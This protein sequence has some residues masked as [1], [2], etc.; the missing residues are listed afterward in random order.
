M[1]LR[2]L[3]RARLALDDPT[4]LS[5]RHVDHVGQTLYSLSLSI[6]PAP[7]RS[8]GTSWASGCSAY[9]RSLPIGTRP[10]H[11][12]CPGA[13]PQKALMDLEPTDDQLAW[14]PGWPACAPIG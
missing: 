14:P 5:A 9:R 12:S 10:A 11:Q 8:S 4:G 3:G 13:D 7:P 2:L 1:A 6:A